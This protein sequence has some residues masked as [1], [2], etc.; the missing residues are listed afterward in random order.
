MDWLR[1]LILD[2]KLKELIEDL[3]I[4]KLATPITT[5]IRYYLKGYLVNNGMLAKIP[6]K[7]ITNSKIKPFM[8]ISEQI[9]KS[10]PIDTLLYFSIISVL[11]DI[12]LTKGNA[13]YLPN[14]NI[15]LMYAGHLFHLQKLCY[16]LINCNIINLVQYRASLNLREDKKVIKYLASNESWFYSIPTQI[17]GI[18]VRHREIW[19]NLIEYSITY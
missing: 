14:I 11:Y 10:Y 2:P 8:R 9:K 15:D 3:E 4:L 7:L 16:K 6:I 17:N 1:S 18:P 5:T 12:F 19:D 13:T